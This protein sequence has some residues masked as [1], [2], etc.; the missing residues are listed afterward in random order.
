MDGPI[1][2][3]L[4]YA[5]SLTLFTLSLRTHQEH[6]GDMGA[7]RSRERGGETLAEPI[8][9]KARGEMALSRRANAYRT[10]AE[11][12]RD[13]VPQ[14]ILAAPCRISGSLR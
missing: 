9:P 2:R 1:I 4:P 12:S 3:P 11:P 5:V 8:P 14:P 13:Y 10:A 6:D 7:G